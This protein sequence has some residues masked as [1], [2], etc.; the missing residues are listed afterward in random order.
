MSSST[1][2]CWIGNTTHIDWKYF[3]PRRYISIQVQSKSWTSFSNYSVVFVCRYSIFHRLQIDH[4][5][6]NRCLNAG[7]NLFPL[8]TFGPAENIFHCNTSCAPSLLIVHHSYEI[9]L[10]HGIFY[11]AYCLTLQFT[12]FKD[13]P[14]NVSNSTPILPSIVSIAFWQDESLDCRN[15]N[16]PRNNN[17]NHYWQLTGKCL[18]ASISPHFDCTFVLSGHGTNITLKAMTRLFNL[19]LRFKCEFKS[20]YFQHEPISPTQLVQKTN[21]KNKNGILSLHCLVS[22]IVVT[23]L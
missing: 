9:L 3:C 22:T 18:L 5:I 11:F 23:S 19:G 1:I 8:T 12:R 16:R 21:K 10:F 13:F 14:R 6:S 15:H 4:S 20:Q 7:N 17:C 2:I